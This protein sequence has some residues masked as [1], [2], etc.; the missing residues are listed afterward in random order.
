AF[1]GS[2]ITWTA[3][4]CRGA[5]LHNQSIDEPPVAH[6]R[7]H[8]ALAFRRPPRM[9]GKSAV[10]V[11]P[12][13]T[14]FVLPHC[15]GSDVTLESA[16]GRVRRG[17]DVSRY[18]DRSADVPLTRRGR[19]LVRNSKRLRVR[20]RVVATDS[21]GQREVRTATFTLRTRDRVA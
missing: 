21:G 11:S 20:A 1:D 3:P 6:P 15:G 5:T 7:P 9:V 14:G 18:C 13:C 8:C 17:S 19:A 2:S 16:N 12:S 10:R 4:A